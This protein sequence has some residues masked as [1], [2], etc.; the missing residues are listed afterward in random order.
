MLSKTVLMI[1]CECHG[2]QAVVSFT[3]P[4]SSC[5]PR[6][7]LQITIDFC[8]RRCFSHDSIAAHG[9]SHSS[10]GSSSC[11]CSC[12]LLLD[13]FWALQLDLT[14]RAFTLVAREPFLQAVRV[15]NV[16]TGGDASGCVPIVDAIDTDGAGHFR[17]IVFANVGFDC[18][19][20]L[21]GFN[22]LG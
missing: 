12:S 16:A 13:K 10:G 3:H 21:V 2:R 9:R 11:S 19:C 15:E 7:I 22:G 18:F 4:A 8:S 17:A 5:E 6:R 20:G 1:M 14:E